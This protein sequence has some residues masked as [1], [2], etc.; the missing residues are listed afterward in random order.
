[1]FKKIILMGAVALVAVLGIVAT[2]SAKGGFDEFGYNDTA[3]VF[4]G[5]GSSW[6]LAGGRAANCVGDYSN[7][8]LVMKWNAAWDACNAAQGTLDENT[9]AACAGAWTNNEWNGMAPGGSGAVWHYK[10]VWI[11]GSCGADGNPLPDGGYCIWG[12]Y[13]VLMDQGLDP[14]FGS[15]HLWFAHAIPNGYGGN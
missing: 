9:A 3:R 2:V 14:S 6:C 12:S 8:K 1:M 10:I 4:N 11:G 7:D 13:E 15:G 5:T